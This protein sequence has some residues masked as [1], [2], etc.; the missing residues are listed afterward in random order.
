[1]D[2]QYRDVIRNI[3][4]LQNVRR[5]SAIYSGVTLAIVVACVTITPSRQLA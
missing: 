4:V 2:P 1:M 3:L 5:P